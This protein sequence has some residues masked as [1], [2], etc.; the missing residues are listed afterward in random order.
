MTDLLIKERI[1]ASFNKACHTYDRFCSVQIEIA[2]D[3]VFMLKKYRSSFRTVAELACGTGESTKILLNQIDYQACYASDMAEELLVKAKNKLSCFNCC[4]IS[5]QD[6][7]S[8]KF[9]ESC[10]LIFC[11]MGLQWSTHMLETLKHWR[12]LVNHR[13]Y[14]LFSVPLADNF[15]EIKS[16]Y[17]P[18]FD[19]SDNIQNKLT[20]SDWEM[21]E[22]KYKTI[23]L[24]FLSPI[25]VL[26]YLKAT[27]VNYN[28]RV[29]NK[30]MVSLSPTLKN[31]FYNKNNNKLTFE[32]GIYLARARHA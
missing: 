22:V 17:K 26:R 4:D 11:N 13:G 31:I 23:E 14:V 18:V 29:A 8:V 32:I 7:Y 16:A 12:S 28:K 20:L 25:E 1:I 15:P 5:K 21:I 19:K 27:G 30:P 10:D 3:A 6:F 9:P 2:T 24:I